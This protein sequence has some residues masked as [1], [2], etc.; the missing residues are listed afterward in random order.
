MKNNTIKE[1]L[2]IAFLMLIV[3][4]HVEFNGDKILP[5]EQEKIFFAEN[6]HLKFNNLKEQNREFLRKQTYIVSYAYPSAATHKK[7][8]KEMVLKEFQDNDWIYKGKT[9][10][11]NGV[12]QFH[13]VKNKYS[14]Y[15]HLYKDNMDLRFRYER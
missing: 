9:I 14:C 2:G 15:V 12:I 13:F 10:L 6:Q 5:F 4:M 11:N 3:F 1:V 8:I 7:E